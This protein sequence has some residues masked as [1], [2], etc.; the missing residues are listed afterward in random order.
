[1]LF[2]A[3]AYDLKRQNIVST[4]TQGATQPLEEVQVRGFELE[5]I[6]NVTENFKLTASYTYA[7]SK[8]TKVGDL[9]DKNRALPLTPEHQVALWADYD[10]SAGALAGFGVGFGARYVGSTDNISVGSVGFVRDPSDG[11]SSAYTVYDAAVRY[12]LRHLDSSLNGA[13]VALN[14]SNLFDKEYLATCDGFY[15]YAGDPRRVTAS[16]N[17]AW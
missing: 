7:N 8:M 16:L 14:V 17:Y 15:C 2:T 11:H 3:A 1:M 10:W 6:G 5:A 13:S 9:R 12:D 4:N